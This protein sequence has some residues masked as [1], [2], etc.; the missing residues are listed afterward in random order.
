MAGTPRARTPNGL[1]LDLCEKC[2]LIDLAS[3]CKLSI[4]FAR[5]V[6]INLDHAGFS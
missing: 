4:R 3:G 5:Q 1:F 2:P 6:K